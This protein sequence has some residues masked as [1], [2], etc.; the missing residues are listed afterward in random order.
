[1]RAR[2]QGKEDI[3]SRGR[4]DGTLT[5]AVRPAGLER[6]GAWNPCEPCPRVKLRLFERTF[7]FCP[8][9]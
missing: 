4:L 2:I 9:D 1:M 3:S 8:R 7:A 5:A 6:A